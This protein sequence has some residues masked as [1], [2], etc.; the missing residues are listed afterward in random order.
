MNSQ[1]SRKLY[2][3]AL[4]PLCILSKSANPQIIVNI[5]CFSISLHRS[6]PAIVTS[7]T[8]TNTGKKGRVKKEPNK[9]SLE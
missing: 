2:K 4:H 8:I 1:V 7:E 5:P 9:S 3:Q 6:V